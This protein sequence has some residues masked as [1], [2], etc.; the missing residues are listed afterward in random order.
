[1]YSP[2]YITKSFIGYVRSLFSD[3]NVYTS[4]LFFCHWRRL[5]LWYRVIVYMRTTSKYII[6][7]RVLQVSMLIAICFSLHK[8]CFENMHARCSWYSNICWCMVIIIY[9]YSMLFMY[10]LT[11]YFTFYQHNFLLKKIMYKLIK[12]CDHME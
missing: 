4:S 12:T 11:I 1:M 3:G 2:V 9:M 8:N 7:N 10:F 5:Y 6:L